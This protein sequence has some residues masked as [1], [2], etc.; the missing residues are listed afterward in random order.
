MTEVKLVFIDSVT[1]AECEGEKE[2]ERCGYEDTDNCL[3]LSVGEVWKAHGC[4]LNM[5]LRFIK[6]RVLSLL[7]LSLLMDHPDFVVT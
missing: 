7:L 6:K 5:F 1:D 2:L 3:C 4:C